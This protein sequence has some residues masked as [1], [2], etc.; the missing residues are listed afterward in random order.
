ME[1][2]L[3]HGVAPEERL[4]ELARGDVPEPAQV[5]D[6]QRIRE[7]EI[8]HD[9]H[10]IGWGHPRVT[11]HAENGHKRIARE[12]AEHHEDD[13]GHPDEGAHSEQRPPGEILAHAEPLPPRARP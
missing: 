6:R 3:S 10:T 11:F 7:T 13:D 9:A 2:E 8:V 12:N 4:T 5:L 1:D